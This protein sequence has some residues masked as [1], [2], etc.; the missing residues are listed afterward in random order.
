MDWILII[1]NQ[2]K[3]HRPHQREGVLMDIFSLF[4]ILF[5]ICRF[6]YSFEA[7]LPFISN[8][9]A[10]VYGAFHHLDSINATEYEQMCEM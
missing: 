8:E 7:P 2:E 3:E 4:A 6:F 9:R 10:I 1:M 5:G